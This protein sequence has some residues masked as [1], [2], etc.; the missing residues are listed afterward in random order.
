MKTFQTFLALS[1]RLNG[2]ILS[3]D[4]QDNK[5]EEMWRSSHYIQTER[6]VHIISLLLLYFPPDLWLQLK[7]IYDWSKH[8]LKL[9]AT[10]YQLAFQLGGEKFLGPLPAPLLSLAQFLPSQ[11]H[12]AQPDQTDQPQLLGRRKFG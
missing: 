3:N 8:F 6:L 1:A 5:Q 11:S 7:L 10:H 4:C 2:S 12:T 9:R